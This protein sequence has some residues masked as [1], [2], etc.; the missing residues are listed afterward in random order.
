MSEQIQIGT[1]VISLLG[2]IDT[3]EHGLMRITDP[4]TVGKITKIDSDT[5]GET[6][7]HVIFPN[8]AWIMLYTDEITD[9]QQYT[10]L[11]LAP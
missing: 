10:L 6:Y 1:Q 2:E 4:D 5:A 11:P 3:D 7:Y 9:A 8:G